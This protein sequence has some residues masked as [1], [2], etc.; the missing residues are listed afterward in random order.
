MYA[1]L[2]TQNMSQHQTRCVPLNTGWA[3]GTGGEGK[4][5]SIRDTRALLN[6]ALNGVFSTDPTL[7]S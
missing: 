2:L 7:S 6:A 3:R 4:R 1:E 5:I